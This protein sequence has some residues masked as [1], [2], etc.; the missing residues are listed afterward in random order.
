M[1]L[2]IKFPSEPKGAAA[3]DEEDDAAWGGRRARTIR[4]CGSMSDRGMNASFAGSQ[5][6]QSHSFSS[7]YVPSGDIVRALHTAAVDV[8]W[9][10]VTSSLPVDIVIVER[11]RVV[12][13]PI[14]MILLLLLV[15]AS[16]AVLYKLSAK[17]FRERGLTIVDINR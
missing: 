7:L 10:S 1:A 4:L 12:G 16:N 8:S 5:R 3:V 6:G 14:S 2:E 17:F 13:G 15:V 9:G 11:R